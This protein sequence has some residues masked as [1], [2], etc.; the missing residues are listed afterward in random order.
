MSLRRHMDA[1]VPRAIAEGL[2]LRGVDV[3]TAQEDGAGTSSDPALMD[4]VTSL[5]WVLFSQDHD[6][7]AEA[8]KRQ[9]EGL[10]F[11]GLVYSHQTRLG[12]GECIRE[13]ELLAKACNPEEFANR[14]EYFPL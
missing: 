9:R 11:S 2:R 1:N 6:L 12:I 5:G 8:A 10:P 14:V 4:R 7:L 3:L 13:L